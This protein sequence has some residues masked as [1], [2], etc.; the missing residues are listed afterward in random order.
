MNKRGRHMIEQE[1]RMEKI[2]LEQE[3]DSGEQAQGQV[4]NLMK[5]YSKTL[6]HSSIWMVKA[7][8]QEMSEEQI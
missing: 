4:H 8:E 7:L 3:E 1:S 2:H 5:K 6:H